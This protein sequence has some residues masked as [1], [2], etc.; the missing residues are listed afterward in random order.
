MSDYYVTV[1]QAVSCR[2][3]TLPFYKLFRVG[4]LRYRSTSCFVSDYYVTVLQAV[5]CRI[6]TLPFYKL[7]RVGLLRYRSTSCFVSDY[8]VTVLQ[9]VSCRITTL[10]FLPDVRA[11]VISSCL[12]VSLS[13]LR[14]SSQN[15]R[16][17]TFTVILN[18]LH[19]FCRV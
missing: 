6:T 17:Q 19:K 3:T 18:K 11:A 5:S 4:L 10:P 14:I 2:I 7:F 16:T 8:Y 1:L 15:A 9:A 13:N 12:K